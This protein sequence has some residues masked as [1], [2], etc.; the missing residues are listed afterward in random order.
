MVGDKTG[1]LE[2]R[3]RLDRE[4]ARSTLEVVRTRLLVP[5]GVRTLDPAAP[6][7]IP[8][9]TGGPAQRDAAYHQGTAWPWLLGPWTRAWQAVHPDRA[10]DVVDD[11]IVDLQ[12][13]LRNAGLGSVSEI[14]DAT[15]PC[16]ARGCFAQAWSVAAMIEVL[17]RAGQGRIPAETNGAG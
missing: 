13:H 4:R 3:V 10:G 9:Y 11:L 6:G 12:A 5:M 7:F 14:L 1:R 8:V 16:T 2:P 15:M 17:G